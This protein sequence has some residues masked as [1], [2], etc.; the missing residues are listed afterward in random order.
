[1]DDDLFGGGLPQT[2]Q[3]KNLHC[4][5]PLNQ[6]I[7]RNLD[8]KIS[9]PAQPVPIRTGIQRMPFTAVDPVIKPFQG[10][11]VYC[12]Q[13]VNPTLRLPQDE[14]LIRSVPHLNFKIVS[15]FSFYVLIMNAALVNTG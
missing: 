7:N 13:K 8:I 2:I 14:L 11:L 5:L 3:G 15:H 10:R 6:L 1:M 12:T 9:W 4:I